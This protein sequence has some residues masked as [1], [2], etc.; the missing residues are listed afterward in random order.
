MERRLGYLV[1]YIFK[2]ID[3]DQSGTL[4]VKELYDMFVDHGL[5][6]NK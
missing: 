1:Q 5:N 2:I 4:D 6:I 3:S